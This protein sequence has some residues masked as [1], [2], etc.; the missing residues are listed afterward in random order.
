MR[1]KNF[2]LYLTLFLS[3]NLLISCDDDDD[4]QPEPTN[5]E[6]ITSGEWKG[7][8]VLLNSID[9]ALIPGVGENANTFQTLRLTVR[10]DNTYTAVFQ[11]NGQEQ[12]YNGNWEF[13]ADETKVS[14]ENLGEMNIERLTMDNMDLTTTINVDNLNLLGDIIGVDPRLIQAFTGG[15]PVNAELRFV[16]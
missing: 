4:G 13:N 9:V 7:D 15:K 16:K 1:S 11:A 3:L 14:L 10:E 6:F 2:L 8:K 5:T 12:T